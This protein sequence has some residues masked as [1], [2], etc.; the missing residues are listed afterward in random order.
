M[1][2]R[3]RQPP[4]RRSARRQG[5]FSILLGMTCGRFKPT[6]SRMDLSQ[7]IAGLIEIVWLDFILS[8]QNDVVGDGDARASAGAEAA[9]R[10]SRHGAVHPA[11]H[12]ARLCADG[13]R[14]RSGFGFA[15]AALLL[16]AAWLTRDARRERA[17]RPISG[18]VGAGAA[19]A[20]TLA[21]TRRSPGLHGRGAGSGVGAQAARY[22]RAGLSIPLQ[23]SARRNSSRVAQAAALWASAGLLGWVAG[24][25][26]TGRL[27]ARECDAAE[28]DGMISRRRSARLSSFCWPM[29]SRGRRI[30]RVAD[31]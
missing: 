19:M 22:D 1:W 15:G 4:P 3:R 26:A 27:G 12:R 30:K 23:A 9:E 5:P 20:A 29:V 10:Q 24:R 16:W 21:S 28:I 18:P 13:L 8:G 17:S 14:G 6:G 11:S 7:T 2:R 25:M 31:E